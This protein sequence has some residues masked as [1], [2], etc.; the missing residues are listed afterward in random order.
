MV[1]KSLHCI[2]QMYLVKS[3]G[4]GKAGEGNRG[5]GRENRLRR[6]DVM[7]LALKERKKETKCPGKWVG[8]GWEKLSKQT[9]WQP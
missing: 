1:R 2:M 6:L 3:Q 5:K 9:P 4:A 8:P 7:S